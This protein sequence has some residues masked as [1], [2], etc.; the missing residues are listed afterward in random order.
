MVAAARSGRAIGNT[1]GGAPWGR[2]FKVICT[3]DRAGH[4]PRV[5]G[6]G[7]VDLLEMEETF[8]LA[9]YV[10]EQVDFPVVVRL[11]GPWF[12]NGSAN[13]VKQDHAFE[14]RVAVE[15]KAIE[16]AFAVTACS[17][18]VLEETRAYYNLELPNAAVIPNPSPAYSSDHR[19]SADD[20]DPD[21]V[22]FVGRFDRHK[23]GDTMLLA[24]Q[25]VAEQFPQARLVFIGPDPGIRHGSDEV[26]KFAEFAA[27]H[28]DESVL[29][30]I[31]YLGKMETTEIETW[32]R[33]A[34]VTV[35]ASSFDNFPYSALESVAAGCPV[36][37]T[38]VGGIPEIVRDGE[39]GLLVPPDDPGAMAEA[40][41]RILSDVGLAARLGSAAAIDAEARFHP[42]AVVRETVT[43][44]RD[45]IAKWKAGR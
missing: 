22:L 16:A 20:A 11:H 7:G 19:W 33:R 13:G 45:V 8:G 9:G 15:G 18:N 3:E 31:D 2:K 42:R 12:L 37:A 24:F 17:A 28:L 10:A 38:R 40:I 23:G 27:K 25:Q 41:G 1:V 4:C 44:Y 26:V 32:R 43:F 5:E 14:K 36:V 39:T 34:A 35:I 6:A 21:T 30:R 29:Q